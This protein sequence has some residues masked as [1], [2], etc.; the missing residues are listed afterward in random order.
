MTIF[1]KWHQNLW[2]NP[3]QNVLQLEGPACLPRRGERSPKMPWTWASQGT[4]PIKYPP[5]PKRIHPEAMLRP[6]PIAS[7]AQ[8]LKGES[9]AEE[10]QKPQLWLRAQGETSS[11][12]QGSA[13]AILKGRARGK[14]EM[15][16]RVLHWIWSW[17]LTKMT[18]FK[19]KK[20]CIFKGISLCYYF[21]GSP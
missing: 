9:F 19:I 10:A 11:Y 7:G 3:W 20:I 15:S 21:S 12:F 6:Q 18:F 8:L 17:Y 13:L 1:E 16:C 14:K 2:V 4:H 5:L